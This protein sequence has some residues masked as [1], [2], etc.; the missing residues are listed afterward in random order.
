MRGLFVA[1]VGL[2]LGLTAATAAAQ[3]GQWRPVTPAQPTPSNGIVTLRAPVA[4]S[5]PVLQAAFSIGPPTDDVVARGKLLDGPA[6]PLPLG[7]TV[8]DQETAPPP[9]VLN[10]VPPG[11]LNSVPP[12]FATKPGMI[13]ATPMPG[14]D[15]VT[16]PGPGPGPGPMAGSPV[17][18]GP[19]VSAM[20][21]PCGTCGAPSNVW[22]DGGEEGWWS[23]FWHSCCGGTCGSCCGSSCTSC[24]SSSCTSCCDPCQTCCDSCCAPR[25]CFWVGAEYLGWTVKTGSLPALVTVNSGGSSALGIGT[26]GTTVVYG[27]NGQD[28]DFRSGARVTLGFALPCTCN[29]LGFETTVFGIQ[30]RTNTAV[31]GP[32]NSAESI[33]RPFTNVGPTAMGNGMDAEIVAL[34]G[35]GINGSVAIRTTNQF[36]GAEE[37]LR[38][39][40]VCGCNGK[41]DFLGGIRYLQLREDLGISENVT[42]SFAGLTNQGANSFAATDSTNFLVADTFNTRNNFYGAQ[43]G[44][45]GEWNWGRWFVGAT[46]KLAIGDMHETVSINGMTIVNNSSGVG[47][48]TFSGGLLALNGTNIG[49]FHRDVF[50]V[51]PELYVKVGFCITERLRAYVGYDVVYLSN[52]V[53][54]GAQIDTN[55]NP[56]YVPGGGPAVGAALP[57]FQFRTSDFWAQGFTAGLEWKY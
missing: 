33:G 31:F 54:P 1:S 56:T 5:A 49:Q 10:S 43:I 13:V 53:R 20:D 17:L 44:L 15:V 40:I 57:G 47:N 3:N 4:D 12:G 24:N 29:N 23:R 22:E 48:G 30:N 37:N 21:A 6:Q 11:V 34:P 14:A 42:Q 45:D 19:P 55:V 52:V 18:V 38:Y 39:P 16:V 50:A 32:S 36:W 46:G 9:S 8:T 35:S 28:F 26:P 7:P 25:P 51:V 27:G 2:A 41:L